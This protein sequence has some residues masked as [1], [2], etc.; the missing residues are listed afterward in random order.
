MVGSDDLAPFQHRLP[1]INGSIILLKKMLL[2]LLREGNCEI[3]FPGYQHR[4]GSVASPVCIG[5][6]LV[7]ELGILRWQGMVVSQVSFTSLCVN[8]G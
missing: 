8:T 2:F 1:L 6:S 5:K 7:C 3:C 4:A